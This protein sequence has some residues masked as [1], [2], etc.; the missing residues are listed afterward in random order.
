MLQLHRQAKHRPRISE[1]SGMRNNKC[2]LV[3]SL[4]ACSQ[5]A[6]V[7]VLLVLGKRL[8]ICCDAF[9]WIW[10]ES[11]AGN[12]NYATC[13]GKRSSLVSLQAATH[14]KPMLRVLVHP[15][16]DTDKAPYLHLIQLHPWQLPHDV[17]RTSSNL[18]E[19]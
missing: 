15:H 10:C 3:S 2:E 4:T 1:Y 6:V 5:I 12:Y 9:D 18:R 11:G 8:V 19:L 13:N 17:Q 16:D 14:A 7:T